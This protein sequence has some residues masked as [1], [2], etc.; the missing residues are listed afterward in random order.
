MEGE[1]GLPRGARSLL[2]PRPRR[3]AGAGRGL[4]WAGEGRRAG[5]ASRPFPL[6]FVVFSPPPP[7]TSTSL[8]PALV[9][10]VTALGGGISKLLTFL[11]SCDV[12]ESLEHA[13][14]RSASS[15]QQA[16]PWAQGHAGEGDGAPEV[17]SAQPV[18]PALCFLPRLDAG[19]NSTG[20]LGVRGP[21]QNHTAAWT[22]ASC[23]EKSHTLPLSLTFFPS[24]FKCQIMS[25]PQLGLCDHLAQS[26]LLLLWL[27]KNVLFPTPTFQHT[28]VST[29]CSPPMSGMEVPGELRLLHFIYCCLSSSKTMPGLA[30]HGCLADN[31]MPENQA[32]RLSPEAKHMCEIWSCQ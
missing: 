1:G 8:C 25:F 32:S 21:R 20:F 31:Q 17:P 6:Q 22:R 12:W 3:S 5:W 29:W 15:H 27:F 24:K 10:A 16:A 19:T 18:R 9:A 4:G 2:S 26:A 14:T 28:H 7:G 23:G 30:S 13:Q 11:H